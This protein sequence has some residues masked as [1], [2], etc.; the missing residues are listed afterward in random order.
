MKRTLAIVLMLPL[1]TLAD[2]PVITTV[3]TQG[4]GGYLAV[5]KP[6]VIVTRSGTL[7]ALAQGR[8]GKTDLDD[9]DL[10]CR[11]SSDGG[12]T[13]GELGVAADAGDDC[14]NSSVIVQLESGRILVMISVFPA[15]FSGR[16]AKGIEPGVGPRSQRVMTTFSD[17]DGRSWSKLADVSGQVKFTPPASGVWAMPGPGLAVQI[18]RGAHAGRIVVP[19]N[20]LWFESGEPRQ[21]PYAV[22]SDDGGVTWRRG[23]RAGFGDD[24]PHVVSE[25]QIVELADGRLLLSSRV[26]TLNARA[27]ATSVDGG[28]TWSMLHLATGLDPAPAAC[29]LINL[30]PSHLVHSGPR[31]TPMRDG[32]MW[33]S[34][35]AGATWTVHRAIVDGSFEYSCL[36]L[37]PDHRLAC[38]FGHRSDTKPATL[39]VKLAR[40]SASP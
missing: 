37:L 28:V 6:Q 17:D 23:E 12:Q 5:R 18:R 15:G 13:W 27:Q 36:T 40:F 33:I 34:G 21:Q 16:G 31:H 32:A 9:T 4:E 2:E 14:V 30:D 8:R 20:V 29:G 7:L 3:F 1:V 24:V 10:I 22:I 25:S 11:R 39:N 19:R 38:I 35:D 26:N